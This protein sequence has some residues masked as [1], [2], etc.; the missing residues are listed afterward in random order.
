MLAV[1][2]FSITDNTAFMHVLLT[3][4]TSTCY[5]VNEALGR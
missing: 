3:H 1:V 2:I 4:F 5:A